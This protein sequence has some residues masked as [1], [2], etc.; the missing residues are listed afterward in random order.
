MLPDTCHGAGVGLAD[1]G[2]SV[3]PVLGKVPYKG[4]RGFLDATRDYD[5]IDAMFRGRLESGVAIATGAVS[6]VWVLDMDGEDGADSLRCLIDEFG[7]LPETVT[8]TTP[9]GSHRFYKHVGGI[10]NTAGKVAP[11]IDTRGDGGYVVVAP[12][13]HPDGGFYRWIR[14]PYNHAIV[15]APDW[16]V[17]LLARPPETF[18]EPRELP[19][20]YGSRYVAVA[21][22]AECDELARTPEG[23][24]NHQLNRSAFSLARFVQAGDI[25]AG[26]VARHLAAAAARAGL[27]ER[28]IRLTLRS[29]FT[30]RGAA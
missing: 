7:P 20:V 30:A 8:A 28:E 3:F 15:A 25:D 1:L 16:L 13:P 10:R 17:D 21:I 14:D 19:Q 27:G 11:G 6:G 9:N 26:T 4:T 2:W 12:S 29:A 18:S 23:Q 5:V 22:E 24:R